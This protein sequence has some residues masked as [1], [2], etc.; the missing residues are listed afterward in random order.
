VKDVAGGTPTASAKYSLR[1]VLRLRAAAPSASGRG[2]L[3]GGRRGS[4]GRCRRERL[5]PRRR[6][7]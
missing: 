4:G 6:S 5:L 2:G 7:L 3:A 1:T